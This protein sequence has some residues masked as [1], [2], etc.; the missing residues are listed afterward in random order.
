MLDFAKKLPESEQVLICEVIKQ[1]I[2]DWNPS[3]IT[4]TK[5]AK[6]AISKAYTALNSGECANDK[7]A[8]AI[9]DVNSLYLVDGDN[10][11]YNGLAGIAKNNF[12]GQVTV[13][14]TQEGLKNNLIKKYKDLIDIVKVKQG[15]DSVDNRIKSVLGQKVKEGNYK[16]IFVISHDKGYKE[17]IEKYQKKYNLSN[18]YLALKN[19]IDACL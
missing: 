5:K 17:L 7:D 14:V 15:K 19:S 12:S 10:D 13:F 9:L 6:K 4:V 3:S 16:K 11:V 2:L 1:A 18:K 8:S